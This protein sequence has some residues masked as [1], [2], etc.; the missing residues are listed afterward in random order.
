MTIASPPRLVGRQRVAHTPDASSGQTLGPG[1]PA[2]QG[3]GRVSGARGGRRAG[4]AAGETAERAEQSQRH[5]VAA[6]RVSDV[7]PADRRSVP[8]LRRDH[9]SGRVQRR[10]TAHACRGAQSDES[11]RRLVEGVHASGTASLD[12]L[13]T[14]RRR[15]DEA[16]GTGLARRRPAV[17]VR[18]DGCCSPV[19]RRGWQ[20]GGH[21]RAAAR[22]VPRGPGRSCGSGA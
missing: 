9:R 7:D 6:D 12:D 10:H 22:P 11:R 3:R 5:V 8:P 20:R 17:A 1:R 19:S 16:G 15:R 18:Q 4:L 14:R 13:R 21:A 2:G